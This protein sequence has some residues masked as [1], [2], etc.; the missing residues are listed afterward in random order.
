MNSKVYTN[1]K[2]EELAKIAGPDDIFIVTFIDPKDNIKKTWPIH[3]YYDE[4]HC[5]PECYFEAMTE[6][7]LEEMAE[8]ECA[9]K[10]DV[11][12][13]LELL[14]QTYIDGVYYD[15]N[16]PQHAPFLPEVLI[17]AKRTS[18]KEYVMDYVIPIAKDTNKRY[19]LPKGLCI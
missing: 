10:E 12:E 1:I 3:F 19:I 18:D 14:K 2:T 7:E 4:L 15:I 11:P 8:D 6:K 5:I 9:K 17:S 16:Y 13:Y